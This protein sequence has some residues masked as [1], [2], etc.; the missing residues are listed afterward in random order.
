METFNQSFQDDT[1]IERL[2][3]NPFP[4]SFEVKVKADYQDPKLLLD[5]V[6]RFK[7]FS[8]GG[9]GIFNLGGNLGIDLAMED[10]VALHLP[11]LLRQHLLGHPL[12]GPVQLTETPD[13]LQ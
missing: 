9:Q 8:K 7:T 10:P 3:S 5:V 2:G 13:S 12:Q 4:A 11:E 6:N 1:L